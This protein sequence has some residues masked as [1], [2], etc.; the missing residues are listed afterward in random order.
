MKRKKS[1]MMNDKTKKILVEIFFVAI[2]TAVCFKLLHDISKVM[3]IQFAD[4]TAYLNRGVHFGWRSLFVDGFVYYAWYK[5]LSLAVKDNVTLYYVNYCILF[6]LLPLLMY[7]LL[8][9]MGRKHFS[10]AFFSIAIL[11]ANIHII[12]WPFITRFAIC[13]I[14]LT[15]LAIFAIKNEKSKYLAALCGLILLLYTRPEYVL[16]LILFSGVSI[17]YLVY[18]FVKSRQRVYAFLAIIT[19]LLSMFIVFIKNPAGEERSVVAFGQHYALN[20]HQEG[21]ITINPN[22]N[23]QKIMK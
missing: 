14:F 6:S 1:L 11:I 23:W 8:R 5:L 7:G 22:T 9:K 3:D 18:R 13:I 12:A 10:A 20:L 17:A 19:L 16:S 4:E 15:C 21:K 2:I